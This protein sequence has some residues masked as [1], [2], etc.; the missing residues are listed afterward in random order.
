MMDDVPVIDNEVLTEADKN[1][2]RAD[3]DLHLRSTRTITGYQIHA[4]DGDFGHVTDFVFGDSNW[5]IRHLVVDS[6]K[7][8]GGKRFL[9]E[10]GAVIEIQWENSKIILSLSTDAIKSCPLFDESL[11]THFQTVSPPLVNS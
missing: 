1:D 6:H 10:A 8:F 11:F 9:V 7:W 3:D 4:S 5:Q 2:K